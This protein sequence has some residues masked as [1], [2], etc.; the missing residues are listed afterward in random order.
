MTLEIQSYRKGYRFYC[1]H[2]KKFYGPTFKN[3]ESIHCFEKWYDGDPRYV[4]TFLEPRTWNEILEAWT[5]QVYP[6]PDLS[7]SVFL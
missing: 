3:F 4:N 5:Q 2:S 6:A 1:K 7:K